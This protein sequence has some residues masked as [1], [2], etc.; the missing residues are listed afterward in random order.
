MKDESSYKLTGME[1]A[2]YAV[3]AYIPG[4]LGDFLDKL[5]CRFDPLYAKWMAHVTILP[6]RPLPQPIDPQLEMIRNQCA[7]IQPFEAAIGGVSTFLPVTGV[8]YLSVSQGSD[9]LTNLHG[10]LNSGR[11]ARRE[12][13]PYVPHVTVAQ[14]V[15]GNISAALITEVRQEWARYGGNPSFQVS[16]LFLVQQTSDNRWIDLAPIPLGGLLESSRR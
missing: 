7:L 14:L 12:P 13:Y 5:R 2:N 4:K 1:E 11:M 10:A 3:V 16:S 9:R 6:P 15:N 8:I